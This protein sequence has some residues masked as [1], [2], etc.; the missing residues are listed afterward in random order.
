MAQ[1]SFKFDKP[2]DGEVN[3]LD[4][5]QFTDFDRLKAFLF[6]GNATVTIRSKSTQ[7]RYTYRVKAP[8]KDKEGPCSFFVAV[9]TGSDNTTDF[10]YLGHVFRNSGD[11]VHGRK[12]TIGLE[13]PSAIAW[14]WFHDCI[15]L[16]G[17]LRPEKVE[18]WHEG[19]CGRCNRKLTVPESI[20]IGL[21]PDCAEMMG[22]NLRRVA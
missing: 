20:D 17:R 2:T 11:Y 18:I 3:P 8:P 16:G 5:R 7:T 4:T 9:L 15:I 6:A 12:S 13:A 19:R 21:G 10:T 22:I 1:G 14:K